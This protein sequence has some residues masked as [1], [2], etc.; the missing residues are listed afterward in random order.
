MEI[1]ARAQIQQRLSAGRGVQM[2]RREMLSGVPG[3]LLRCAACPI[4]SFA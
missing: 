3:P 2:D 1:T 4:V